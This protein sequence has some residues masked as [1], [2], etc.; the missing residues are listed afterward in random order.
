MSWV[1]TP[2]EVARIEDALAGAWWSGEWLAIQF[3]TRPAI[4]ERLLPP[5]LEPAAEPIANVT[6][7][8]WHSSCLGSWSGAVVNVAARHE[9]HEGGYPLVMYMDSEHPIA[10]GRELFG[11]PKKLGAVGLERDG[12]RAHGWVDRHGERLIDLRAHLT[13]DEEPLRFDRYSFN[14]KSRTAAGGRGLEEDAILTRTHFDV[15]LR[16]Q[17][18]G[19]GELV[20]GHTT[21]DPL[22]ELEVVE[23]RRVVYATDVTSAR[24]APVARIPAAAFLPFHY[25][26]QDDWLALDATAAEV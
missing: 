12:D 10:F 22:G 17:R 11:E 19:T 15:D 20:L 21:H 25:G 26:R 18:T 1:K 7:G 8:R 24:C 4:V 16:S 6:V 13:S 2:E 9:G 23:V 14:V 3:L 5:P